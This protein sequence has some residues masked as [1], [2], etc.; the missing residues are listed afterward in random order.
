MPFFWMPFGRT[1]NFDKCAGR[2]KHEPSTLLGPRPDLE[3]HVGANE[4][5][6]DEILDLQDSPAAQVA[7]RISTRPGAQLAPHWA[8]CS[9]PTLRGWWQVAQSA[10]TRRPQPSQ[11]MLPRIGKPQNGHSPRRTRR[12]GM[13]F[14]R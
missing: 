10:I 1:Q 6:A 13:R 7:G 12:L 3:P 11:W 5:G 2:A 8:Q 9:V 14:A 4:M